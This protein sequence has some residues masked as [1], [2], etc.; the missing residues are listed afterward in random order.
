MTQVS[1]DESSLE[2]KRFKN[3]D[4]A[5]SYEQAAELLSISVRSVRRLVVAGK[6]RGLKLLDRRRGIRLSTVK[7]YLD[8]CE[9]V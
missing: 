9:A 3:V 8:K 4:P 6:L 2:E 1:A 5:V 7:K